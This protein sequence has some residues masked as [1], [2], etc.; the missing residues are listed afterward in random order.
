MNRLL[1]VFGVLAMTFGAARAETWTVVSEENFPPYN[2]TE[3]GQRVGLDVEIVNAV[4]ARIGVTPEHK[5]L[6]WN[7]VVNDLD[8]DQTDIAF[9]FVGRPDRFEKYHMVGPHRSGD[10]V[11]VVRSDSTLTFDTLEDLRGRSVGTVQGFTYTPAF[12]TAVDIRKDPAVD[13][14]LSLRKLVGGRVDA[15]IGDRL[16]LIYLARKAG[17]SASVKVLPKAV[18]SVPRYIA[19][20]R[21]RSE[22][23]ARFA[24][25]LKAIQEDGTLDALIAQWASP[26]S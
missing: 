20:P 12:D 4:L 7:R 26:Q 16:T 2:Y 6:P 18:D 5:G 11:L 21:P 24:A 23:A 15:V 14:L 13:T 1:I 25:G 10:T 22:K 17:L 8:Q 19:L 3:N 9:Q